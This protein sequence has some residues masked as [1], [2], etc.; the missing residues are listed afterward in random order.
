MK[1]KSEIESLFIEFNDM[2]ISRY[3]LIGKNIFLLVSTFNGYCPNLNQWEM[4]KEVV[5]WCKDNHIK[6]RK[7]KIDNSIF[8]TEGRVVEYIGKRR[9]GLL[10]YSSEDAVAF[11]LRWV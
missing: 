8:N 1:S 11:K 6:Y 4:S 3:R 5:Q 10:F 7:V 2:D 9:M